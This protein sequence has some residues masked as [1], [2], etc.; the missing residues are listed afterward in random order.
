MDQAASEGRP[1]V[2]AS[3]PNSSQ[4]SAEQLRAEIEQTRQQLGDTVEA[5]AAKTDVKA[6]AKDRIAAA[7]SGALHKKNE[8]VA[9]TRAA[10]P[11]SAGSGASKVASTVREEPL[12]FAAAGT[13]ATGVLIGWLVGRR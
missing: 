10:T 7:R 6:Q 5:L 12:P 3:T 8:L 11:E 13:F 1:A 4:K 2:S 9:R